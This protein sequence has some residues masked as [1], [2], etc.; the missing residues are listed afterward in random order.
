MFQYIY[1]SAF[2]KFWHED[3]CHELYRLFATEYSQRLKYCQCPAFQ[4]KTTRGVYIFQKIK[5][6]VPVVAAG[7][8]FQK[9][10]RVVG[11]EAFHSRRQTLASEAK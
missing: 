4:N 3:L 11:N 5:V 6:G 7:P 9:L 1:D 8:V 10:Q 2:L